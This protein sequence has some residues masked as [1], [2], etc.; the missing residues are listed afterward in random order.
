[1]SC[2]E[3]HCP[4]A[5]GK[6]CPNCAQDH[7]DWVD[8]KQ[9]EDREWLDLMATDVESCIVC[10]VELDT[11][12]GCPRGCRQETPDQAYERVRSQMERA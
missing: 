3:E 12:G 4:N 10:A 2:T 11:D 5:E 8:Q 7:N 9:A 6:L 1:M